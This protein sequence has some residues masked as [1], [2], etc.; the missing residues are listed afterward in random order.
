MNG[1]AHAPS[2]ELRGENLV[3][4]YGRRKVVDDVSIRV[5]TSE[6]VGLLG[7][8]G[9]GKTTTFYM[10]TGMVKPNGG[11]VAVESRTGEGALFR[12]ILPARAEDAPCH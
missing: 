4:F 5:T 1:E 6:I 2:H 9:A 3:K 7:P 10:V 11:R 12:V 8:N